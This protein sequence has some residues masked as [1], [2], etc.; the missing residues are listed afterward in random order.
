MPFEPE[1]AFFKMKFHLNHQAQYHRQLST[2]Q[3]SPLITLA[4][5]VAFREQQQLALTANNS[6]TFIYGHAPPIAITHNL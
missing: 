2:A 3:F 6:S 5:N 1:R 4:T